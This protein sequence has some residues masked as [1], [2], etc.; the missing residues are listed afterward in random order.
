[1]TVYFYQAECGDAARM[2]FIGSDNKAHNIFI[3]AGYER[4]F[5]YILAVEIDAIHK[6]G[7]FIDAWIVSHIHDDHIG[8]ALSYI[9]TIRDSEFQD[10]VNDWYY[11]VPRIS[12]NDLKTILSNPISQPKSI[13][14]GDLLVRYLATKNKLPGTDITVDYA[15]IDL[16]GMK[17]TILSP[18]Q[19]GLKKLRTKY[20]PDSDNPYEQNEL[21]SVSQAKASNQYDYSRPAKS[22]DLTV[23][24]EDNSVENGS[25][26]AVLSEFG[27]IRILWL[28]DGHP[29]VII[30]SLKKL[31][32][33]RDNPIK[34]DL[35]KVTHHGSKGNN[36]R[37]LY[38]L[39]SCSHYVF[40]VN[41]ENL[42]CL[43]SKECLVHILD[44]PQRDNS[45]YNFYFTY[46]N[47]ILRSIFEIDDES[48]FT[49][50]NFKMHYLGGTDKFLKFNF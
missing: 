33:S 8:G 1:M 41:G 27:G 30:N 20:P 25:S 42:H 49:D 44:N 5:R 45:Q 37:N 31:G 43:P 46:D 9:R 3:D 15:P 22:F 35:V 12:A 16:F 40:S 17:L 13:G 50:Y 10:I 14:Q 23:W 47:S 18:D 7:E 34:C 38:E 39:I 28:A 48:I 4:T 2:T 36:S 32:Y 19:N 6:R 11:N 29:T 24:E 21:T 26:I